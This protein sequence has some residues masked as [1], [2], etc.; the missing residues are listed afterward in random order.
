M[1]FAAKLKPPTDFSYCVDERR[2]RWRRR[3][4][5][6]SLC[7]VALLRQITPRRFVS[8]QLAVSTGSQ[9]SAVIRDIRDVSSLFSCAGSLEISGRLPPDDNVVETARARSRV[10]RR[11][12]I[13]RIF[14]RIEPYRGANETTRG[15]SSSRVEPLYLGDAWK[16]G[17]GDKKCGLAGEFRLNRTASRQITD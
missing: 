1:V 3:R 4:R 12:E 8:F 10:I 5:R 11:S 15:I 2:Q 7:F 14:L 6:A 16:G 9:A 13:R 17:G